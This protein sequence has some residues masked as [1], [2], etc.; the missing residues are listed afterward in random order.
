MHLY[1]DWLSADQGNFSGNIAT[2]EACTFLETWK[3]ES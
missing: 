3:K 1:I 2:N